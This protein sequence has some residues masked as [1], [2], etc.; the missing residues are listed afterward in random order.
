MSAIDSDTPPV[1]TARLVINADGNV[2]IGTT[3]PE[4]LFQVGGGSL[5]VLQNGN[6]GVGTTNPGYKVHIY[7]DNPNTTLVQRM[8]LKNTGSASEGRVSLQLDAPFG[9]GID[10][11][12]QGGAAATY[13]GIPAGVSGIASGWNSIAFA[14]ANDGSPVER[15]RIASTGNV[16]IGTTAPAAKLDVSGNMNVASGMIFSNYKTLSN[17]TA[18]GSWQTIETGPADGLFIISIGDNADGPNKSDY[19]C[20]VGTSYYKG[21]VVVLGRVDCFP[22]VGP[23]GA[24]FRVYGGAGETKY[25]QVNISYVRSVNIAIGVYGR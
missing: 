18:D 24:S 13:Q 3:A 7:E 21:D 1:P 11:I 12:A 19:L 10:I 16:G 8:V 2:G 6:V 14:T 23:S 20:L 5:T 9:S 22:T 17:V 25:L 15:I 4:G